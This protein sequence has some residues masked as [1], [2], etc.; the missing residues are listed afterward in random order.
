[1]VT[2]WVGFLT[3]AMTSNLTLVLGGTGKT[4]R[5]VLDLLATRGVP[6]RSGF[7]RAD[8]RFDWEDAATWPAALEN[9]SAAYITFQPDLAV[10]GAPETVAAFCEQAVAAGVQRLVLLSGRGE[11]EAQACEKVVLG[12]GVAAT[13]VRC[14]WFDQNFSEDFLLDAVLAGELVL[15]VGEVTEPF[16]DADDIAEVVAAVLTIEGHDGVVYELTGPELLSFGDVADRLTAAIDRPVTFTSVRA[17]DFAAGLR[18]DGVPEDAMGLY[19]YLFAEVLD[20]RNSTLG[21]GVQR[22]L[23]RAPRTFADF[24][25]NASAAWSPR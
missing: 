2:A 4:G 24:A 19:L 22:V 16:V 8:P 25:R 1:M 14:S 10:P 18:S 20:G 17:Q 9:V 23:G 15:P 3:G 12:A 11:P 6:T 5:R 7:R 21:D 13:V